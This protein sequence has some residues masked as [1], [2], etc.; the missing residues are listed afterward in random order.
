MWLH[1]LPCNCSISLSSVLVVSTIQV[2]QELRVTSPTEIPP[3]SVAFIT[4]DGND[5]LDDKISLQEA[6]ILDGDVVKYK[7]LKVVCLS[8]GLCEKIAY[9]C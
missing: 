4:S 1:W 8:L 6:N 9:W 3:T 7:I 2:S 5:I